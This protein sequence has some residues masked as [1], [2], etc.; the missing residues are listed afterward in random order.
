MSISPDAR[1]M[2]IP[3]FKTIQL[4]FVNIYRSGTVNSKSFVSKV[5]LQIKCYLEYT[6]IA[7]PIFLV[8]SW[9]KN[10]FELKMWF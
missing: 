4:V 7:N 5:F 9:F 8:K 10:W 6:V 2:P 3:I 1:H